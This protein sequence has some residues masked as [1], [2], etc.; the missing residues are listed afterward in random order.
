MIELGSFR[1]G[2]PHVEAILTSEERLLEQFGVEAA[3]QLLNVW[4]HPSDEAIGVYD[5]AGHLVAGST[6]L[7][8]VYERSIISQGRAVAVGQVHPC[9]DDHG[10]PRRQIPLIIGT[11]MSALFSGYMAYYLAWPSGSILSGP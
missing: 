4:E 6:V 9:P 7:N 8:P 11:L 10:R 5:S 2:D 1:A 3:T